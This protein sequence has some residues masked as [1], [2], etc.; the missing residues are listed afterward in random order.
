MHYSISVSKL[1]D[2]LIK[3]K[4]NQLNNYNSNDYF[5]GM[6]IVY[7]YARVFNHLSA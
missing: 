6:L 5:D 4:D 7:I 1:V 3:I 2:L